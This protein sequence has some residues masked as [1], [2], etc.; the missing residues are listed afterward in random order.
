MQ[1]LTLHILVVKNLHNIKT[2][3]QEAADCTF[4]ITTD[5]D[6]FHACQQRD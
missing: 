1:K 5:N 6:T 2:M 4:T 3:V